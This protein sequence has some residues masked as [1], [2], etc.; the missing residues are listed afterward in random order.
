MTTLT[1]LGTCGGA[2][3]TTLA[4][5]SVHLLAEH[6]IRIP[7]L[8]AHD[9]AAFNERLGEPPQTTQASAD[10]LVDGGR[11]TAAKATAALGQGTLALVGAH[12]PHG[13]ATLDDALAD[14]TARFGQ[15]G[16][17]RTIPVLCATYG[18]PSPLAAPEAVRIPFDPSLGP[19]GPAA[20]VTPVLRARTR[21]VL[22]Q[23][24]VPILR[25]V[26]ANR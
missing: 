14:I 9:P 15:T 18:R 25:A 11:Y 21:T 7:V 8:I 23:R 22:H 10:E 16:F 12:T 26:Y 19:G 1:F 13:T 3:A 17:G 4:A 2:G 24:W 6:G 20:D 5:L